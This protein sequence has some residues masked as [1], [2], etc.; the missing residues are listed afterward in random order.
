MRRPRVRRSL[1]AMAALMVVGVAATLLVRVA[2]QP[3]PHQQARPSPPAASPA[4][5]PTPA[6]GVT[7]LVPGRLVVPKIRV[8]APIEQVTVD[9]DDDMAPP[10]KP[11]N[12]GWY[13]PGVTPGQAGDAVI[14][15]HLDWYGM[16]QAV[17]YD[18]DK[19]RAGDEVDV[20]SQGGVRL[21]FRVT[22]ST[23]VSRTA[24]PAGL[25]ATT[26]APRLTL[27]TCVGDWDAS[28]G[29]YNQR[30]LVDAS[31]VGTG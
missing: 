15:G 6:S 31:Y 3:R 16:P 17:F 20:I 9:G 14:D 10:R 24:R 5:T 18:L 25:F 19:L 22:D 28:A 13:A 1:A 11:T 23:P 7:R 8:D 30:L 21:R 26:G 2:Y 12:V 29:Q 4:P 27:V